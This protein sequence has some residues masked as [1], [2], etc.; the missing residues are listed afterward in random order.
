MLFFTEILSGIS[1]FYIESVLKKSFE[2]NFQLRALSK[3]QTNPSDESEDGEKFIS[4]R[5]IATCI[6]DHECNRIG[7]VE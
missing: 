4:I 5:K 1:K 2:G 3:F 6:I 7:S